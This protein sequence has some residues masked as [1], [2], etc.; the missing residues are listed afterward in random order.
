MELISVIVPVYQVEKY[1]D[2]CVASLVAQTYRELEI[3]LVDDGSPDRCGAMCDAW[4]SRDSRIVVVHKENGGLSDARNA[5]MRVARGELIAFVDSDDWVEPTMYASLYNRMLETGSDI[6]S[7]GALRVWED[8]TPNCMMTKLNGDHVL[9]KVDA[10]KALIDTSYLV[11]TVWNKL[12]RRRTI[13]NVWFPIGKINED[14]FWSWKV[15]AR[16]DRV[17]TLQKPYY[18]YLQRSGSIMSAQASKEPMLVIEAKCERHDY[19]VENMPALKNDSCKDLIYTCLFQGQMAMKFLPYA[20][21]GAYID[22]M[23]KV[24][25]SHRPDDSYLKALPIRRRIRF[26]MIFHFLK[27]TCMLQNLLHIGI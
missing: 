7:C 8:N 6:A 1:L 19:I 4:A 16:A 17:A 24:I 20:Q 21:S 3:I 12:Y 10:M 26:E 18:N 14:E 9:E 23:Q 13:Q 2:R 5:G 25:K 27:M 11:M 15:I 22:K